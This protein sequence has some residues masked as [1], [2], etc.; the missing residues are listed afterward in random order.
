MTSSYEKN[1]CVFV[2]TDYLNS[3]PMRGELYAEVLTLKG[4]E[5]AN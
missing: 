2:N 4:E 3:N 5:N 1:E